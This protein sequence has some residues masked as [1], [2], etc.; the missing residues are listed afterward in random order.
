MC[1]E[2]FLVKI[3]YLIVQH[4]L[5]DYVLFVHNYAD[6]YYVWHYVQLFT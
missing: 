1:M 4:T 6:F 3:L 2:S 5:L